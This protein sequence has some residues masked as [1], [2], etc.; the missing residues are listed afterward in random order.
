M[1]SEW[2]IMGEGRRSIAIIGAGSA[3][4]TAA[5]KLWREFGD[6]LDIT[7]YERQQHAGGRAWDIHFAGSRIE[8]GG[9]LLHSS[10]RHIMEL[11]DFTGA[12]EGE[13]GLSID[14]KDETYG[15]W[16]SKGFPV[17]THTTLVSMALGIVKH[18]GPYAALKVTGEATEMAAKWEG[19]YELQN[20]GKRFRHPDDLLRALG[21]FD[22]T[23]ISL[24]EFLDQRYVGKRMAEDIVEAITHNMYN[25]GL[26]MN[27]F[28]GLVGLAGAGLA[29]GYLFAVEGG[30]WTVFQKTLEGIGA[31]VRYGVGARRVEMSVAETGAPLFQVEADDGSSAAYDAVLVA[32]PFALSGLEVV[33]GDGPLDIPVHPYQRVE[34]AFVA[35]DINPGYFRGKTGGRVPSTAYTATSAGAPFMSIGVTGFS[36]DYGKRIYK[37][38]SAEHVMSDAEI[39]RIFERISDVRRFTWPGAYPVLKPGIQH[40]PFELAP[41]LYYGCAFETAA[42]SIEVEA[43]GGTN[44]AGLAAD[45]LRSMGG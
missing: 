38:F 32:A 15:F 11:M 45:Y 26:E 35:G 14:G 39:A 16:T 3:G 34:C 6:S 18:V 8:V 42:G 17:F 1:E 29:G 44:A 5:Y 28:A 40:V 19:V 23:Q 30:N 9:T 43:V 41:G 24:G 10:G 20:A 12:R 21:L 4:T 27:A 37:I 13:S 7:V 31:Q 22:P 33:S 25:Q 36:P 2:W